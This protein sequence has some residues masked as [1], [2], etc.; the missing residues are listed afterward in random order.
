MSDNYQ[1]GVVSKNYPESVQSVVDK[2][3]NIIVSESYHIRQRVD[4]NILEEAICK[5]ALDKF[6]GGSE[7]S[8]DWGEF[9][10]MVSYAEVQTHINYLLKE[11]WLD[12]IE[13]ENGE[14]VMWITE[15][16]RS[17]LNEMEQLTNINK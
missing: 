12:S 9:E 7:M 5:S 1:V 8:W 17:V 15:K 13:N 4:L 16:G 10:D 6:I 14:E 2:V 11:G 3:M